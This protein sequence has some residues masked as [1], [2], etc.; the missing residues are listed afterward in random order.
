M[1]YLGFA[2]TLEQRLLNLKR[3]IEIAPI[4]LGGVAASGGGLP[5]RPGGFLGRLPQGRVTYDYSELAL[6]GS[7]GSPTLLD[8]L[9][10]IRYRLAVVESA[11][12]VGGGII[13]ENDDVVVS[14]EITVLDFD[15]SFDVTESPTGEANVRVTKIVSGTIADPNDYYTNVRPEIPIMRAKADLTITRIHIHGPDSTPTSEM[16]LD[17]KWADDI[18]TGSFANASVIDVC[19]TSSGVVTI[20]AGFDD[21]TVASGKYIYWS[22]DSAP[23]ADWVDFW[24][25]IHYTYD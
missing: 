5:G 11:S 1:T 18:F 2:E 16:A 13:V 25:E 17:L 14:S 3:Q 15:S 22:M 24:F 7:A 12:G 9:N 10:H 19:D 4:V 21:A 8:N 20:T 23:H 6:S